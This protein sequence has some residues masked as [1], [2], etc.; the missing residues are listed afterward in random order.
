MRFKPIPPRYLNVLLVLAVLMHYLMPVK[1][2]IRPAFA[3]LGIILIILGLT[4]NL[5][6]VRIL[7]GNQ[8]TIDF[9]KDPSDLVTN[10]PFRISRNPIY[11]SGVMA[12]AGIAIFL[13][14]V[15]TFVFP[16]M[17]LLILDRVYIP[18]EEETLE[19]MFGDEYLTYKHRVRRWL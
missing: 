17:L 11:L 7:S 9:D 15:I 3:Y 12:S 4:L 16:L 14:S 13:G 1:I 8:T 5:W 6:A 19:N 2:L 10:G 18:A